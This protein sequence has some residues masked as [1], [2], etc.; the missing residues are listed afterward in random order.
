MRVQNDP[1]LTRI[2]KVYNPYINIKVH[3]GLSCDL[4]EGR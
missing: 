1:G 4:L 2:T 3:P